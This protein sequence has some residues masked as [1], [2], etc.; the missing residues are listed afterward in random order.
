MSPPSDFAELLVDGH[1]ILPALLADLEAARREIHFAMFLFFRDP[2]GDEVANTLLA[3]ARRGGAVR[4]L[5]NVSKTQMGD[6]FSTGEKE[7]MKHDPHVH[8]DAT[9]VGPLCA[10][11]RAGGVEVL[12]TN[13]D[14]DREIVAA[15]ARLRSIA[16]QIRDTI[17]VDDLHID[18]RKLIVIDGRVAYCG[19][20]NVGAQ[21]LFHTPFD[22]GQE[23]H[24]EG[25]AL[26]KAD[27]E[28]PW[29]KWHDS[30]TRFEG[31]VVTELD[32]HFRERWILD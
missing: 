22:P 12:D 27:H 32:R 2:I 16:A 7:M 8:H 15:D 31:P 11:L 29:W 20:A 18:H 10:R 25:E 1:R 23:A 6:P 4:V 17:A 5:L 3:A 24:A 26:R 19:G 14:Y 13:I 9:D 30:L 28:E 21:Y